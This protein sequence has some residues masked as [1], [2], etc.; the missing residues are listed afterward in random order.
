MIETI[1]SSKDYKISD[2]KL[3]KSINFVP[4]PI[5]T[6]PVDAWSGGGAGSCMDAAGAFAAYQGPEV[7]L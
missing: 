6:N 5:D 4:E 1:G 3:V 2:L 7:S